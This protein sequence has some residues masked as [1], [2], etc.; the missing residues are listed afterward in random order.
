MKIERKISLEKHE[1]DAL[2]TLAKIDCSAIPCHA[3]NFKL[4]AEDG[5]H[6]L[7]IAIRSFLISQDITW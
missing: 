1:I 4:E 6:C 2:K 3:C 5:K 7:M